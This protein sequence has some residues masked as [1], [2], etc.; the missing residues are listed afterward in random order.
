MTSPARDDTVGFIGLGMMGGGMAANILAAKLP[1]VVYDIDE[2]KT[3]HFAGLGAGAAHSP[4]EVATQARIVIA[5][6]DTTAQS[7]EVTVMEGGIIDGAQPGDIVICMSTIDPLAVKRMH[8]I[9]SAKGIGMIDSP[10]SGMAK[11]AAEGTLRAFVGGDAAALDSSRHVLDAM[12][13]EIIHVGPLGQGL[14]MKL[15]NNML[16]KI[17]SA[18]AVEG[19]VLGVKAGLDPEMMLK[20]IGK[21]T[22]SSPAFLYRAQRMIERDFDGIRLD[23]SCKDLQ[24]EAALG[25][26]LSVP[27]FLH[28]VC[29]QIYEMGRAAGFGSQDA[30]AIVKVYEQLTGT[31]VG[32]DGG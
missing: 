23:I 21:S 6:V 24:L 17:N 13:S 4:A 29:T 32:H 2:R 30:T 19:M 3:A 31:S 7:E 28:S 20:V 18:A 5:M 9:L 14:I 27:L 22:G 8:G 1:L 25:R 16:Y 10:V 26:S 11:G 12:T 15:I